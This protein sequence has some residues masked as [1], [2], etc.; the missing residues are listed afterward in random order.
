MATQHRFCTYCMGLEGSSCWWLLLTFCSPTPRV[1]QGLALPLSSHKAF[2]QIQIYQKKDCGGTSENGIIFFLYIWHFLRDGYKNQF[3]LPVI[4]YHGMI[5][6][7]WEGLLFPVWT[8]TCIFMR[9]LLDIYADTRRGV[10]VQ[11]HITSFSHKHTCTNA[12]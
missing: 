7:H 8:H 12:R 2:K 10:C 6:L 4:A 5:T 3:N 11:S 9:V 1:S